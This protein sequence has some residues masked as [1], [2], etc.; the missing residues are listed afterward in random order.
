M[1]LFGMHAIFVDN[2]PNFCEKTPSPHGQCWF[3]HWLLT[4][5]I[6]STLVARGGK[7]TAFTLC[8]GS[9]LK[10]STNLQKQV[11]LK[12]YYIDLLEKIS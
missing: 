10:N 8:R 9:M 4:G 11:K 1:Q 2:L 12:K 3:G 6:F 5:P 7:N